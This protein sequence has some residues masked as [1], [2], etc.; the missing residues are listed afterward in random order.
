MLKINKKFLKFILPL[1]ILILI[2]ITNFFDNFKN[3]YNNNF[4]ARIIKV[5]GFCGNESVGYLK[6]LNTKYKL[7]NN[8]QIVNFKHTPNVSWAIINP[9]KIKLASNEI[10][11]LN[12]P[13]KII[14]L[15]HT[16]ETNNEFNISNSHFYQ[17]KINKI[18]RIIL[19]FSDNFDNDDISLN[20]YYGTKFQKKNLLKT[21]NHVYKISKNNYQIDLDLNIHKFFSYD[22]RISFKINNLKNYKIEK[23]KI[24]AKNKFDI[25]NYKVIDNYETCFL[26][27]K[28]D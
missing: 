19:S 21:F 12:Y 5:Y 3:I 10:I 20:V 6:Y 13:G 1:I 11:L 18:D 9:K 24:M 15:K 2:L 25:S 17:D 22:N 27:R 16:R 4:E 23:M 28:N 7:N 26:I 8:P 14:S